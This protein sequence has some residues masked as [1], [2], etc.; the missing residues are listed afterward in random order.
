MN[1]IGKKTSIDK[2]ALMKATGKMDFSTDHVF[3]GMLYARILT[4]PYAHA[5]ITSIDTSAA[6]ALAGVKAVA[7]YQDCPLL[8][9]ELFYMGQEV[10]AV[11]AVDPHIAA[12]AVELIK[13]TYQQLPFVLDAEEAM[14]STSPLVGVNPG[15]NILG[16][17]VS[18]TWGDTAAGFAASDVTVQDTIGWSAR[19]GHSTLEPRSCIAVWDNSLQDQLTVYTNSQDVFAQ[20]AAIAADLKLPI[21]S[22]TVVAHGPGGG[23]GDLGGTVD[24]I[25]IAAVLAKKAGAPVQYHLTR[26]ENYLTA[27]HQFPD[28][29]TIKIGAKSDGTLVALE[30][31]IYSDVGAIPMPLV[32]DAMSP[33]QLTY[34]IPNFKLT[35]YSIVTNKPRCGYFRC[36]GEPGGLW[37]F[38]PVLDQLAEKLHM[39][40]VQL[41]IKNSKTMADKDNGT[42]AAFTSMA[43][44]EVFQKAADGIGWTS[45]WHAKNSKQLADGRYHGMGISGFI[46]NK[47]NYILQRT[48]SIAS[49]RDGKFLVNVGLGGAFHETPSSQAL[50]AAEALGV[51]EEDVDIGSFGDTSTTQDCSM[52]AGS[53]GMITT[54]T[55]TLDAAKEMKAQLFTY[56]AYKLSTTPDKLDA[57]GGKIFL[58]SDPTKFVTHADVLGDIVTPP[59]N[60]KGYCTFAMQTTVRTEVASAVEVAVDA[61]TGKVEVLNVVTADDLGRAV[62]WKGAEA[63]IEG[64]NVQ[65]IGYELTWT[66]VVDA[67]N[68]VC[69]NPDFLNCKF[70]TMKDV[71]VTSITPIIVESIDSSGPFGAKGLG[72]PPLA[73]PAAAISNAIYNAVGVWVKDAPITPWKLLKA[74]GKA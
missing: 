36:V 38:E 58:K 48:I 21:T 62:Y 20:R 57:L 50:L 25:E 61:E 68:G 5:K 52:M 7:T 34:N 65:S 29:A 72:E 67:N 35:G 14:K 10:A 42:G 70:P 8:T 1:V 47:G 28:K 64:G 51:N 44:K 43:L 4:S 33:I 56:A 15:S 74:L 54:G 3:E 49:T 19:H 13:V 63:Q 30:G 17:P 22:V 53:S 69:L 18:V 26:R 23:F 32:G 39:D 71:P 37:D 46:C 73:T 11:A 12:Q 40:P 41:R 9:Q 31:T 27:F 16:E 24:H 2:F 60:S 55:A 66:Q 45:K 6:T 59:L